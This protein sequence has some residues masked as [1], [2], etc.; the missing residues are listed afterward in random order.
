MSF[1]GPIFTADA[2]TQAALD[3]G[4]DLLGAMI[5]GI[6]TDP[7]WQAFMHRL[8]ARFAAVHA[9]II[10]RHPVLERDYMTRSTSDEV[11]GLGDP[12]DAY[13]PDIDPIPYFQMRPFKVYRFSEFVHGDHPFVV[14]YLDRFH[15]GSVMTCRVTTTGGMQAWLSLARNVAEGF[16]PAEIAA[17]ER[18]AALFQPALALFGEFKDLEDQRDVYERL[19]RARPT[20]IVRV[21]YRGA[22]LHMDENARVW[23]GPGG[24]LEIRAGRL[25]ATHPADRHRI[26]KALDNIL[27]GATEEELIICATPD[28]AGMEMLLLRTTDPLEP[29]H[30]QAPR[31]IIYLRPA[32]LDRAPSL[33]R[34][35]LLFGLSRR[36]AMLASL[37]VRGLTVVEAAGDLGISEQTARTYLRQVFE[38]TGI[39]R[40]AE[41]VRKLQSSI[42]T[43]H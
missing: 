2:G 24:V 19:A 22:I 1:G 38:K 25:H 9:S 31:A 12:N 11:A 7:P 3:L 15:M 33:P 13:D 16:T 37:L 10:F 41:L 26:G 32:G 21:D 43:V 8:R 29:A 39:T 28:G 34:L 30:A 5:A 40:Q 20:G 4:P 27:A 36:E 17:L 23:T 6:R 14:Q 42:A 35:K 18:I